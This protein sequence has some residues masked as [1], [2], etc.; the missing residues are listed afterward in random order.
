MRRSNRLLSVALVALLAIAIV[1]AVQAGNTGNGAKSGYRYTLNVIAFENCPTNPFDG[2][3]RHMIA[4]QANYGDDPRG[5]NPRNI[6]R[7]NDI[8][9]TEGEFQVLRGNAC[10][11]DGALFQLPANPCADAD[12]N[13]GLC[14]S[15]G[16]IPDD[17]TFQEY[18]AFLRLV[19]IKGGRID[20]MTCA[21]DP[22]ECVAGLCADGSAC[23]EDADCDVVVCSSESIVKTRLVGKNNKPTFEDVTKKLLTLV[24][25]TD[26]DGQV[27]T[28]VE[29]FNPALVDFFW[30]WNTNGRP[31][32]QIFFIP[33]PD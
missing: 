6:V 27:D 25:D 31:H 8:L 2:S 20:V 15:F 3:H 9:L 21:T 5:Q 29:L 16:D 22:G 33:L 30:N 1:P 11:E 10:L 24:I 18:E 13:D 14:G 7:K 23:G 12:P 17:P 28:R 32:A 26:G 19:G 4:V